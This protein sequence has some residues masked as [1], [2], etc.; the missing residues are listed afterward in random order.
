MEEINDCHQ[1]FAMEM[2]FFSGI[3]SPP[4]C[5]LGDLSMHQE[6]FPARQF[7]YV[8]NDWDEPK[9]GHFVKKKKNIHQYKNDQSKATYHWPVHSNP[10]RIMNVWFN[11]YGP[12]MCKQRSSTWLRKIGRKIGL[13]QID[14]E[15]LEDS[16]G[17]YF[18]NLLIHKPDQPN[19]C[20]WSICSGLWINRNFDQCVIL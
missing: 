2:K 20:I 6:H 7:L 9:L 5:R 3:P 8:R 18:L 13:L 10:C 14:R 16:G 11:W 17:E 12:S 15:N 1:C 19:R 4:F